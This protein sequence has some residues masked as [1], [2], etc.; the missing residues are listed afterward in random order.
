MKAAALL[1]ALAGCAATP[2]PPP[3]CPAVDLHAVVDELHAIAGAVRA[4]LELAPPPPVAAP[5]PE[6]S[7]LEACAEKP[8]PL[9]ALECARACR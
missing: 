2:L 3:A 9:E 1:V 8:T 7:C 6:T 4:R 5:A